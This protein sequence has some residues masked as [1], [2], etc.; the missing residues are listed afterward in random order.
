[1]DNTDI[2][3]F[4]NAM[5]G[6]MAY[7]SSH[8]SVSKVETFL[9]EWLKD[10]ECRLS[11]MT[12]MSC[13]CE[14]LKSLYPFQGTLYRGLVIDKE[15]FEREGIHSSSLASFT[16]S[17]EIGLYFAGKSNMYG[18]IEGNNV[19]QVLLMG[20]TMKGV[21][22]DDFLDRLREITDNNLLLDQIDE[23]IW[24]QEKL[25]VCKLEELEI[26]FV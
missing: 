15:I 17:K 13:L 1:M 3:I 19:V 7:D 8:I 4:L 16:D 9:I 26:H 20:K 2:Q 12:P 21:S 18:K 24:E 22:F 14:S 23:R 5:N 10:Q 11:M 6:N 25:H